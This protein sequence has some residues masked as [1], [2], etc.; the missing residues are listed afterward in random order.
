MHVFYPLRGRLVR[1]FLFYVQVFCNLSPHTHKIN[2]RVQKY[3][4]RGEVDATQ[5]SVRAINFSS[6]QTEILPLLSTLEVKKK[7]WQP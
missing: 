1:V 3:G 6:R 7:F 4:E 5:Y 2:L